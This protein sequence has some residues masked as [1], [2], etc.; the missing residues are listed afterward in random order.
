MSILK[1]HIDF[2]V[3]FFLKEV[4][5]HFIIIFWPEKWMK[6]LKSQGQTHGFNF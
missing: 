4:S 1:L 3:F 6:K 2:K 5:P